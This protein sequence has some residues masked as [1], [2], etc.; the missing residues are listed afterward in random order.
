MRGYEK[1][2]TLVA[3]YDTQQDGGG[4]ILNARTHR[5]RPIVMNDDSIR[6]WRDFGLNKG[7][8]SIRQKKDKNS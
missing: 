4:S 1:D 6:M 2:P 8:L 3:S 5:G 7:K